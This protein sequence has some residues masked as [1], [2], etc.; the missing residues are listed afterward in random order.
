MNTNDIIVNDPRQEPFRPE[1]MAP[2]GDKDCFLA[3]LAAGADAVY[4]GLKHFSA[5]MQAQNFSI[6]ELSRLANLAHGKG[7][8]VYVA[9]NTLVKPGD[10]ASAGRLIERGRRRGSARRPDHPG[11]RSVSRGAAGGLCG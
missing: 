7:V 10:E 4:L 1:I 5:R 9:M 2:A 6:S 3:A 11:P 8:K